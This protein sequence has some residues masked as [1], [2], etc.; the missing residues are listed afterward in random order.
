MTD[1]H[2]YEGK[3]LYVIEDGEVT[4]KA[5]WREQVSAW[6]EA[7]KWLVWD[8]VLSIMSRYQVWEEAVAIIFDYSRIVDGVITPVICE[9][10]RELEIWEIVEELMVRNMEIDDRKN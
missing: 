9:V 7:L 10:V 2:L 3:T 1:K 6:M 5:S 4:S 8:N